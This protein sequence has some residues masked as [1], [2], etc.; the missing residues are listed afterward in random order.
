M[1]LSWRDAN[2]NPSADRNPL[3]LASFYIES[4]KYGPDSGRL[5][6]FG[7]EELEA[8][9]DVLLRDAGVTSM[10]GKQLA[11]ALLYYGVGIGR[12]LHIDR[13]RAVSIWTD[14]LMHGLALAG[15][16]EGELRNPKS[17]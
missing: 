12:T 10:T 7:P 11:K 15:H 14:G 6:E 5:E 9:L 1:S 13:Q 17:R 3:D 16:I 2:R 8:S 4:L